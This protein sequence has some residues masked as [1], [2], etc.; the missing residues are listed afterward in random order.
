MQWIEVQG[1]HLPPTLD[2]VH[3]TVVSAE[4]KKTP[5]IAPG[6][7][8]V[9]AAAIVIAALKRNVRIGAN[10]DVRLNVEHHGEQ[11][12]HAVVALLALLHKPAAV[13]ADHRT[14]LIALLTLWVIR[15]VSAIS[16]AACLGAVLI[17]V[18]RA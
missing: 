15:C 18:V 8:A 17:S 10:A 14:D 4:K 7:V 2:R 16:S 13:L 12:F 5:C 3:S 11:N 1:A 9:H 6:I